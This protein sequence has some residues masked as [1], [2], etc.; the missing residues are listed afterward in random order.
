M[1]HQ[2]N[3]HTVSPAMSWLYQGAGELLPLHHPCRL[4]CPALL[5]LLLSL[6]EMSKT[7]INGRKRMEVVKATKL[8]APLPTQPMGTAPAAW[9]PASRNAASSTG[10]TGSAAKS[11]LQSAQ[12]SVLGTKF[13]QR[14]PQTNA[15]PHSVLLSPPLK[16]LDSKSWLGRMLETQL[17]RE[18]IVFHRCSLLLI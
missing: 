8:T 10:N 1:S 4:I 6:L 16:G 3:L 5:N 2:D 14:E 12:P 9:I 15:S 18:R 11:Q 7:S 13:L 17:L